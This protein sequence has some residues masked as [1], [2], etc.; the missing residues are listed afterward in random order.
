MVHN[1]AALVIMSVQTQQVITY[2]D[3]FIFFLV[4]VVIFIKIQKKQ[5]TKGVKRLLTWDLNLGSGY[6]KDKQNRWY[7]FF[8]HQLASL[9]GWL[10]I[11]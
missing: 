10:S 7:L 5:Q 11:S 9:G 4:C 8:N 2:N 1:R 3:V 6:I